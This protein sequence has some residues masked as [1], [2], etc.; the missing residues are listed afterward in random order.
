MAE[1]NLIDLWNDRPQTLIISAE[2][3]DKQG[4]EFEVLAS[5]PGHDIYLEMHQCPSMSGE[6]IK[7]F[8]Y[9]TFSLLRAR[10][11]NEEKQKLIEKITK[12]EAFRMVYST[13]DKVYKVTIENWTGNRIADRRTTEPEKKKDD[14]T[15]KK[16]N[17]PASQAESFLVKMV[18]AQDSA[19]TQRKDN[20]ANVALLQAE[21]KDKERQ[22][23]EK[24]Y[25]LEAKS[26]EITRLQQE[27]E[28][29][30]TK[31]TSQTLKP[32]ASQNLEPKIIAYGKILRDNPDTSKELK[33][34]ISRLKKDG[35]D[36]KAEAARYKKELDEYNEL[37]VIWQESERELKAAA[38]I[39][40]LEYEERYD[41]L[42]NEHDG[43]LAVIGQ[44][45]DRLENLVSDPNKEYE[46]EDFKNK[47]QRAREALDMRVPRET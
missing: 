47:L 22:L 21:L 41:A 15:N 20:E 4:D 6:E 12:L 39:K 42:K 43:L 44:L 9:S 23:D 46:T 40:R 32:A 30:L 27:R 16:E 35:D 36:S 37:A 3:L 11:R 2:P 24:E 13:T 26:K 45:R 38:D 29:L 10:G 31:T 17:D 25:E 8:F 19:A 1:I 14:S 5:C 18:S 34:E 28:T 33:A 7:A